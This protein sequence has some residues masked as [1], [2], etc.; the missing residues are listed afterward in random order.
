M[1][2]EIFIAVFFRLIFIKYWTPPPVTAL[3]FRCYSKGVSHGIVITKWIATL[4]GN[5]GRHK[6]LSFYMTHGG[7]IL[8]RNQ[9]SLDNFYQIPRSLFFHCILYSTHI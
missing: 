6:K 1:I 4:R 8:G 9:G 7:D 2:R 3:L 5:W